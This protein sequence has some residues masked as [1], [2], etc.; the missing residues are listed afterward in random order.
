[1]FW[2]FSPRFLSDLCPHLLRIFLPSFAMQVLINLP[3]SYFGLMD[4]FSGLIEFYIG[5]SWSLYYAW[6]KQG[7]SLEFRQILVTCYVLLWSLRLGSF[8]IYRMFRRDPRD[9]RVI[10]L[11]KKYGRLARFALWLL[12]H[13]FWSMICCLPMALLHAFP[14][15]DDNFNAIDLI[16]SILWIC[17]FL[18]EAIADWNKL[19]A[20]LAEKKKYYHLGSLWNYSRNPNHCG[21][22]FCW[23]GLSIISLNLVFY[24]PE[25]HYNLLMVIFS[26]ISPLFTLFIMLFE[27]TLSSE[28][29][30]NKRFHSQIDYHQYRKQ[31]SLLW[32]ISPN[33]Y[34]R[35]PQWMKRMIFFEW[36]MY[37]KGLKHAVE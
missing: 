23:L 2:L 6:E 8:L 29:N 30:N 14:L 16:G 21:E 17:G 37:N 3:S 20:K 15:V 25:Y 13:A 4:N 18:I 5:A 35:L 26:L 28:V 11:E 27:A 33:I 32:P 34:S 12:P 22:V 24:H 10:Q 19:K 9:A 7:K 1:M 36:N 31:T